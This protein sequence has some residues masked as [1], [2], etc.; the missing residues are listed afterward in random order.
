M[1]KITMRDTFWNRVYDL[2]KEDKNVIVVA[3]D[4]GA[5]ALDKFRKDFTNQFVYAGIAEQNAILISTGLALTGKKVFAYAI[6]PFITLRCYEQ[7]RNY[8][9]GMD[10]PITIVGVGA[11]ICYEDSGP[12]HHAVEDISVLRCLPN[13]QIFSASDNNMTAK[14]ADMAYE[15]KHPNYVRLDRI[16]LP[17]IYEEG[18]DFQSGLGVLREVSDINILSTGNM[19]QTALKVSDQLKQEGINVG[20]IDAYKIP[21]DYETFKA[22]TKGTKKIITLEEHTLPGGL[23]SQICEIIADCGL[24]IQIKRLGFDFRKKYCYVYGGREVVHPVYGLDSESVKQAVKD[25]I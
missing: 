4:M 25:M 17:N 21:V 3:A 8:P 22:V 14:F 6:A 23:G 19:I 1:K 13:M 20:V 10:L 2:A 18:Y 11:G 9:A 16:V 12:T 5:P 24:S 15:S 7:I